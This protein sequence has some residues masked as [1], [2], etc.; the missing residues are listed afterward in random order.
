M[1]GADHPLLAN[2]ATNLTRCSSD[3]LVASASNILV[4]S[5][6]IASDFGKHSE[7]FSPSIA[8]SLLSAH[9]AL[10]FPEFPAVR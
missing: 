10:N 5:I 8:S 3:L 6:S 2:P 4:S 7:N 9:L 1:P